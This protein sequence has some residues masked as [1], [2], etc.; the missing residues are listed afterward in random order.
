M[1]ETLF[2]I[3]GTVSKFFPLLRPMKSCV[4]PA[5]LSPTIAISFLLLFEALLLKKKTMVR[6]A[7]IANM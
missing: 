5:P 7:T 2:T 1:V 6:I 4:L 3:E